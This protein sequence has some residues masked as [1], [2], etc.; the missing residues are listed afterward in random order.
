MKNKV[1]K[2]KNNFKCNLNSEEKNS[3]YFIKYGVALVISLI[4]FISGLFLGLVLAKKDVFLVGIN[5]TKIKANLFELE[6]TIRFLEENIC[7]D[8]LLM[9]FGVDLDNVGKELEALQNKLFVSKEEYQYLKNFYYALEINHYLL[10]KKAEK[11]C[12]KDYF[13]IFYFYNPVDKC[14]KCYEEGLYLTVL[15]KKYKNYVQIY[16]FNLEDYNKSILIKKM[17]IKYKIDP[18]EKVP[19]LIINGK[20]EKFKTLSELENLLK[21]EVKVVKDS[22]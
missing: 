13:F 1:K 21:K 10:L 19:I 2:K 3:E 14:K 12:G 11:I 9:D 22:Q 16:N 18:T 7:N 15:K 5:E 4:T 8:R 17:L 20:K 6:T